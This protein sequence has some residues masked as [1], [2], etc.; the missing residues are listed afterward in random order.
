MASTIFSLELVNES[1]SKSVE[2]FFDLKDLAVRAS[3]L[4][5][6]KRGFEYFPEYGLDFYK[7][8]VLNEVSRIKHSYSIYLISSSVL[9]LS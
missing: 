9:Y 4:E 7:Q 8:Y 6:E 2:G 1:L 3:I 5:I